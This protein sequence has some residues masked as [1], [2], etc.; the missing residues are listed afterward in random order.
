MAE[1][2]GCR[3]AADLGAIFTDF[4]TLQV[5]PYIGDAIRYAALI[6][7]GLVRKARTSRAF[8]LQRNGSQLAATNL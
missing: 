8:R 2:L 5:E 3:T 4:F 1:K 7:Q 6:S